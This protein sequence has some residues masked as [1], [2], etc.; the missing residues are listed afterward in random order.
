MK[1]ET[2]E[3]LYKIS[4]YVSGSGKFT[5]EEY[6]LWKSV[7]ETLSAVESD[8]KHG[9]F[10]Q[11]RKGNVCKA[12]DLVD[13]EYMRNTFIIGKLAWNKKGRFEVDF[14]GNKLPL[15]DFE[16]WEKRNE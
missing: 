5:P 6:V 16:N 1:K 9:G 15:M 13:L 4:V 12:G 8:V 11:D 10:I 2:E 3:L 7:K 14:E